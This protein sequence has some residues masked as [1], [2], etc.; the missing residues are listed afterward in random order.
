MKKLLILILILIP[1]N[2]KAAE[3]DVKSANLKI[4]FSDDWYVFTRENIENNED[5]KNIKVTADYM[6]KFFNTNSA[7]IDAIKSNLEFVLRI[8]DEVDF[9]SLTSYPDEKVS[10]IAQD[11]GAINK[12]SDYK[13]YTNK[14]KYIVLNYKV[15]DYYIH[16]YATVINS[17]WYTFTVQKKSEFKAEEITEIKRIIDSVDYTIIEKVSEKEKEI[18]KEAIEKASKTNRIKTIV[19][20]IVVVVIGIAIVGNIVLKN[21]SR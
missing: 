2:I 21:K 20:Y 10:E 15:N 13:T 19:A 6:N 9:E 16:I 8:G 14:Y 12:T 18:E 7:Y 17:K 4:S 11:F 3:Y 1:I 5:L